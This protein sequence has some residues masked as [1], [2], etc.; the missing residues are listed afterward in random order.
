MSVENNKKI[1][2][3]S[4]FKLRN[5]MNG[6]TVL[7]C[8]SNAQKKNLNK[9]KRTCFQNLLNDKTNSNDTVP[10]FI[11]KVRETSTAMHI[12]NCQ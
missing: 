5:T 7:A 3:P 2:Q 8:D 6:Y 9:W 4:E 1:F 12:Y 10:K 11:W